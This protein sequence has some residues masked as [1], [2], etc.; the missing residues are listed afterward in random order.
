MLQS[1]PPVVLATHPEVLRLVDRHRLFGFGIGYIDAHLLAALIL[2]PDGVLWTRDTR[3]T[4]AA[5]R[6]GLAIRTPYP[7]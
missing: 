6:V 7:T 2:T 5:V 4:A 1:L 3:L